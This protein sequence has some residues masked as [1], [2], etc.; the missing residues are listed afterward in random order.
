M[1]GVMRGFYEVRA[2]GPGRE[3]FRFFCVLENGTAQE[4]T[5]RGLS[6]P[7]IAV[8]TS[9]RKPWMTAFGE[10]DYESVRRLGDDHRAQ[11]PRRIKE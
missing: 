7:A 1:H 3:Q 4:L 2:Q 11:F 8:I 10:R 6:R 9:L 5:S